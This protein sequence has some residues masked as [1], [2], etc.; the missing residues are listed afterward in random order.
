MST[1]WLTCWKYRGK[2]LENILKNYLPAQM[3]VNILANILKILREIF[4]KHVRKQIG[5]WKAIYK[6]Q[7][8]STYWLKYWKY[9]GKCFENM[10]GNKLEKHLLAPNIVSISAVSETSQSWRKYFALWKPTRAENIFHS[11]VQNKVEMYFSWTNFTQISDA[12]IPNAKEGPKLNIFCCAKKLFRQINLQNFPQISTK[13]N[14][15]QHRVNLPLT[16]FFNS[17][18]YNRLIQNNGMVSKFQNI[19]IFTNH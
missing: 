13:I 5:H 3:I 14:H 17:V 12:N 2:Y 7:W 19:E 8:L 10:L 4:W 16:I 15:N 11:H 1:Y 9:L 18:G 6:H